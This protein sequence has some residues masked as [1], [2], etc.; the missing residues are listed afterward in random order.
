M[1]IVPPRARDAAGRFRDRDVSF[2]PPEAWV[3]RSIVAFSAPPPL[4]EKGGFSIVMTR[5]GADH[6]ET[7][8]AFAHRQRMQLRTGIAA[9]EVLG[10]PEELQV[11]G[12]AALLQRVA[13]PT[14]AGRIEQ[15]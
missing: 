14:P 6:G 3:D 12:K 15:T 7:L 13:W 8:P 9:F 5:E 10:R 11:G 2:V 4:G 1:S